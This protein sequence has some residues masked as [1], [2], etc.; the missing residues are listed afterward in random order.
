MSREKDNDLE[1]L[2]ELEE[3]FQ[4][5]SEYMSTQ[6]RYENTVIFIGNTRSGKSSLIN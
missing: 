1:V 5:A 4:S 3:A 2:L 6:I